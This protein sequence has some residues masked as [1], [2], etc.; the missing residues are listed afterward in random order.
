VKRLLYFLLVFLLALL[1]STAL[2]LNLL[3]LF[4]IFQGSYAWAFWTGLILDLLTSQR[5][6][7]SSL[8]FLMIIHFFKLYSRKYE[9]RFR[10]LFVFVFFSSWIFAK[11]QAHT[12]SLWQ[13]ILL[14]FLVFFLQ[15]KICS[16]IQLKLDL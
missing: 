10:F 15:K 9:L 1:Q 8:L 2:K 4:V 11:I 12:W 5:L 7:L 13:N 3:L 16:D 6:G 14:S